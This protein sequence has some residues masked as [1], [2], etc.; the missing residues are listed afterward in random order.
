M[1]HPIAIAVIAASSTVLAAAVRSANPA[2]MFL[3]FGF[4]CFALAA[5]TRDDHIPLPLK[6]GSWIL[7]GLVQLLVFVSFRIAHPDD[8]SPTAFVTFG[9]TYLVLG[10]AFWVRLR[11]SS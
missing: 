7:V 4:L 9:I 3:A 2:L 5:L 6:P 10:T 1:Q 11:S 8:P